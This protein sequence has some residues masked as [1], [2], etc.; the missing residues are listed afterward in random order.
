[1]RNIDDYC[2]LMWRKYALS[3]NI[4]LEWAFKKEKVASYVNI[5]EELSK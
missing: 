5:Q 4:T 2:T 3:E 1:M